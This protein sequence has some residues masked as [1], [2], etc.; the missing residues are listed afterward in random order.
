MTLLA[1]WLPQMSEAQSLRVR[2]GEIL[3]CFGWTYNQINNHLQDIK[4]AEFSAIQ[5][6]S[7]QPML[8][9]DTKELWY[10]EGGEK[11][12]VTVYVKKNGDTAPYL[13]ANTTNWQNLS[14]AWPGK[15]MYKT[16]TI[17]SQDYW[18][19]TFKVDGLNII[20]NDGRDLQDESEKLKAQTE[21]I[22]GVTSDTFYELYTDTEAERQYAYRTLTG[23]TA[24]TQHVTVYAKAT[25]A[26][27]L[28]VWGNDMNGNGNSPG[29]QMWK[30]ENIDGTNYYYDSF[31]AGTINYLFNDGV[32]DGNGNYTEGINKTANIT[33]ITATKYYEVQKPGAFNV[34][35]EGR[36]TIYCKASSA[37][38]IWA[39][40]NDGKNLT[41]GNWP[42]QQMTQTTTV[43]GET[44]YY[45]T[46]K[47]DNVNVI[48]SGGNAQT[49]N[50]T[51]ITADSYY[52]YDTSKP[53]G[54]NVEQV[55]PAITIYC[56]ASS[57]PYI[58]AWDNDG[59]NLTG[60]NW[61]GQQ[62]TKT[63]EVDGETY[64]KMTFDGVTSLSLL[65]HNNNSSQTADIKNITSDR[66]FNYNGTNTATEVKCQTYHL[67]YKSST[68][69]YLYVWRAGNSE[70][71]MGS[72][73][74]T[75]ISETV[76]IDG[77]S[78]YHTTISGAYNFMFHNNAGTESANQEGVSGDR[79]YTY[80][81][82]TITDI[83]NEKEQHT[84][85]IKVNGDIPN[86]YVWKGEGEAKTE[87]N[88]T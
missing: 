20:F 74:G 7:V 85:Y 83:T 9:K 42:G 72:W 40:D 57:A 25:E 53:Q 51:N 4:D 8:P 3:N 86:L 43:N 64:Y 21:N 29:A 77:E 28:K 61:P 70:E 41:G 49:D 6:S 65:F 82:N 67:Y 75:Q 19:E 26:P 45:K 84:L 37:P 81:N 33:N 59:K 24:P 22:E 69:P 17:D 71:P 58:W 32:G 31:A 68:Q 79:Y 11:Q 30:T 55:T 35:E 44:F 78:Y 76:T 16:R 46:F 27:H 60:G 10:Y 54:S 52:V 12:G 88:G 38:Y 62:M 5:V 14:G 36:I 80:E 34:T 66:Y 50:I 63:A 39:W 2:G 48:F 1:A 87:P 56:K 73:P 23:I 18:Y 15:Q 13:Y 47:T